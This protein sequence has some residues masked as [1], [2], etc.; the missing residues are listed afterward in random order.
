VQDPVGV[1]VAGVAATLQP[2]DA[3]VGPIYL[4]ETGLPDS[5][6]TETSSAGYY[7]W[8]NIPPG[9]HTFTLSHPSSTCRHV[10]D[11]E[12]TGTP[13]TVEPDTVTITWDHVCN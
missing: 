1:P 9:P 13:M 5:S 2:M 6:L 8:A 4:G 11:P 3:G 7:G 10:R 12:G